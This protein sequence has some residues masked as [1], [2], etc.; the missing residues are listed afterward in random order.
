MAATLPSA[1]IAAVADALTAVTQEISQTQA[2]QNSPEMQNALVYH[3]IQAVLDKQ[4]ESI[5]DENLDAVRKLIADP[6]IG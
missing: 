2:L 6:D 5:Q 4:R 1:S 3:R